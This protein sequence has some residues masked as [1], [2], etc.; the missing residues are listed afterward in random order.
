MK[1]KVFMSYKKHRIW[2]RIAED[3]IVYMVAHGDGTDEYF[4]NFEDAMDWIDRGE[5]RSH[6]EDVRNQVQKHCGGDREVTDQ[7][8]KST[9]VL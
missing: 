3:G 5:G 8:R 2:Y 1:D 7:P 9:E 4:T 6:Y